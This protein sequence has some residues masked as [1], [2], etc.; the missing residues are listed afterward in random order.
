MMNGHTNSLYLNQTAGG[1]GVRGERRK[2]HVAV[3]CQWYIKGL[4]VG[5]CYGWSRTEP[6]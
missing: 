4:V 2:M 3:Y 5:K 1:D 6:H